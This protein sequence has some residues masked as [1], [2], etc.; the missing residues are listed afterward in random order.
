M[1]DQK[2]VS[3]FHILA[4]WLM[5]L[6]MLPYVPRPFLTF[7]KL[8]SLGTDSWLN[9]HSQRTRIAS[10]KKDEYIKKVGDGKFCC[11]GKSSSFISFGGMLIM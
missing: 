9:R 6:M 4:I 5:M 7:L 2:P 11:R 3:L 1:F 10:E 8:P